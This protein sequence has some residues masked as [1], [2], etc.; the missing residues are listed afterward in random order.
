M[1]RIAI[2]MEINDSDSDCRSWYPAT[3]RKFPSLPV[4]TESLK[5]MP[6]HASPIPFS[7]LLACLLGDGFSYP[8]S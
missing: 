8:F 6:L 2:F 1:Q 4:L 3:S 7:T 5:V